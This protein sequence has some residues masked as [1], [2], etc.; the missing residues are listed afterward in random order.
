MYFFKNIYKY[1]KSFFDYLSFRIRP[2]EEIFYDNNS[3][4][5]EYEYE[6]MHLKYEFI[7]INEKMDR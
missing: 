6:F 3:G 7:P 5:T 2:K 4:H 1:L